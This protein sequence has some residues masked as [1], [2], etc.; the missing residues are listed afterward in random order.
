MEYSRTVEMVDLPGV[1]GPPNTD[2]ANGSG[3]TDYDNGDR[4]GLRASQACT[5]CRKMKRKCSKELPTCSL[6]SRMNR[7]CDYSDS[8]PMPTAEEFIALRQKVADLE[9]KLEAKNT[10]WGTRGT[11]ATFRPDQSTDPARG[12]A[13]SVFPSIFL[14]D[15]EM[16][17]VCCL[18][19]T[20][21]RL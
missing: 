5:A 20:G 3:P 16:Y 2:I 14:L 9:S 6:C 8:I 19:E 21:R 13:P 11:L 1:Y 4:Y 10:P 7:E 12:Q 18:C 17:R 15:S